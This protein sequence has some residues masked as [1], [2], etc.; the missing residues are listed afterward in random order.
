MALRSVQAETRGL[1]I[2]APAI[3]CPRKPGRRR[4]KA[5]A[6]ALPG[7]RLPSL[8]VRWRQRLDQQLTTWTEQ[9][10]GIAHGSL[11]GGFAQ[12]R[13]VGHDQVETAQIGAGQ[14]TVAAAEES[15]PAGRLRQC[16]EFR[17]GIHADA[18]APDRIAAHAAASL[19]R[20]PDP[21]IAHLDGRRWR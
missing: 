3:Q 15:S 12:Q 2:A 11:R 1:Q 6:A 8:P 7:T 4:S 14:R 19:L 18:F 9:R 10:T 5:F 21:A 17:G 13:K 16:H 20:S